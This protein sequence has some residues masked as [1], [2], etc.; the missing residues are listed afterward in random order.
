MTETVTVLGTGIMG[1]G[2]ARSLAREGFAVRAWN[3]S[4][5]KAGPLKEAGVTVV[6]DAADAV[7][8]ADVVLTMLFDAQAVA[9]VMERV[10]PHMAGAVWVQS[11]TI[12]LEATERFSQMAE[13]RGIAYVDAPVLGTKQPAENGR[14]VVIAGGPP[15]LRTRTAPLF[16][17][18]GARTVW[19]GERPGDGQR[20]KLA[21]NAWVLSLVAGAAQSIGLAAGL[22]LDPRLF[23]EAV[24]GGPLDCGYLQVKGDAMITGEFEPSFALDGALKDSGL[25]LEAMAAAGTDDRLMRSLVSE[26][27]TASRS[28]HGAEDM[29]AVVHAFRR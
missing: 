12:G 7:S 8:G 1:S 22:G 20:L 10:L 2:I 5:E 24:S 4:P 16:D 23:L 21:A 11:S 6:L 27:E 18:I 17:A 9:Q 29:A 15:A 13:S 14:L 3:R 28:G 19:A 25:I 26:L